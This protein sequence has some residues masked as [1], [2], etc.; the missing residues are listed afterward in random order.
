MTNM[1]CGALFE[2]MRC[3]EDEDGEAESVPDSGQG[4][5]MK[6][7]AVEFNRKKRKEITPLHSLSASNSG[8]ASEDEVNAAD[9]DSSVERPPFKK[10]RFT[11]DTMIYSRSL[12][13]SPTQSSSSSESLPPGLAIILPPSKNPCLDALAYCVVMGLGAEQTDEDTRNCTISI[14]DCQKLLSYIKYFCPKATQ[15]SNDEYRVKALKRWFNDI[16]TK[17]MRQS[18]NTFIIKMKSDRRHAIRKVIRRMQAFV[19]NT[20]GEEDSLH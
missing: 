11:E 12:S 5:P 17:K 1:S 20:D 15:T 4:F 13:S 3:L 16:P 18:G 8:D 10:S 14:F 19:N 9:S 6:N 2:L 7:S